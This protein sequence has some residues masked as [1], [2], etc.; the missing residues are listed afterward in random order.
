MGDLEAQE[1]HKMRV[2]HGEGW[3]SFKDHY[4]E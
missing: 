3:R 2:G 1:M 4:V